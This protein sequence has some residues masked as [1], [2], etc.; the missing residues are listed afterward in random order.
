MSQSG[1]GV[2]SDQTMLVSRLEMLLRSVAAGQPVPQDFVQRLYRWKQLLAEGAPAIGALADNI[3]HL[4]LG[5]PT[6]RGQERQSLIT[7][8]LQQLHE[9]GRLVTAGGVH[10]PTSSRC[11]PLGSSGAKG[12]QARPRRRRTGDPSVPRAADARPIQLVDPLQRLGS[13]PSRYLSALERLGLRTVAD[14]LWHEPR[15]YV[16]YSRLVPIS[17][18]RD[19][20]EITVRITVHRCTVTG[21]PRGLQRRVEA[22][23]SDPTGSI[24]AIW[25]GQEWR[26][27]QRELQPGNE[28]Y[29]SGRVRQFGARLQFTHPDFEEVGGEAGIHTGRLVPIYPL[30]GDLPGVWLRTRVKRALDQAGDQV[31]ESLPEDVVAGAGLLPLARALQQLHFPDSSE[32]LAA[33]RARVAFERLLPLQVGLLQQRREWHRKPAVALPLSS[34]RLLTFLAKL[35]FALTPGQRHAL[36]DILLDVTQPHPMGRLLQGDVGSGKTVVAAITALAAVGQGCQVAIIAPTEVLAEQHAQ[37]FAK[38]F[39]AIDDLLRPITI[40]GSLTAKARRD[41][42]KLVGSGQ[43]SVVVGTQS[44]LNEEGNFARLALVI[45]DEQHRFGVYQRDALWRKGIHPHLLA[46]TAT[47]IPRTL[48]LVQFSDLDL[49]RIDTMPAGRRPIQTKFVPP[50]RRDHLFAFVRQEVLQGRQ[51]YVICPLIEE[52]EALNVR[53]VKA[54]YAWLKEH[55]QLR[56]LTLGLL[57]GGMKPREKDEVMRSFRDG[58]TQVLV[59]TTVIEV[60]VDVPNATVMVIEG[61]ERFGLAQLHQ[62]RGRVGRGSEQSYCALVPSDEADEED[63]ERLRLIARE[64]DG[65]KLAEADLARRGAGAFFGGAQSGHERLLRWLPYIRPEVLREAAERIV[66]ADPLLVRPEHAHLRSL[67]AA[68]FRQ[69]TG[70]AAPIADAAEGTASLAH[71]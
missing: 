29:V 34:S 70:E 49:S 56:D 13:V 42:W 22:L 41:A 60:G 69:Q 1:P 68:L 47:P 16:D 45:I 21:Y 65:L 19:G 43:A 25:F 71:V 66:D 37:T 2:S 7:R 39:A 10:Q 52:N 24:T 6:A 23:F 53:S 36:D 64:H 20:Q 40:T 35:P 30:S 26:A 5:L 44:L 61:A 51:A 14:L 46:M 67:V 12:T 15:R 62:L 50:E 57:H 33:A 54:E 27:K 3:A 28:L 8:A 9:L 58:A 38:L 55:P 48:A 17:Q 63:A 11:N 59:S 32:N 18:L 31:D 4:L